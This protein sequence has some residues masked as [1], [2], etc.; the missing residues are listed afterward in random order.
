[1]EGL[2]VG[3]GDRGREGGRMGGRGTHVIYHIARR[4]SRRR[5]RAPPV[6]YVTRVRRRKRGI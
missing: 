3:R 6:G 4:R 1:V 5:E 2:G